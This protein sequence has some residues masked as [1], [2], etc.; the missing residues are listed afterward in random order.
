MAPRPTSDELWGHHT[1][2][3][4][5]EFTVLMP[6]G[7][8]LTCNF[9]RDAR[10]DKIKSDIW[11]RAKNEVM[12][13]LMNGP[14][15]YVFVGVTSD[16][17]K[18]DFFDETRRLCELKLFQPI[19]KLVQPEGD[20]EEQIT[21]S[22]IS[23]ALGIAINDFDSIKDVE[24]VD[25]RHKLLKIA[26]QSVIERK[27]MTSEQKLKYFFPVELDTYSR[28]G[29]DYSKANGL[30]D[31]W[32]AHI[33][34]SDIPSN[35]V[36]DSFD[37]HLRL[38][39]TPKEIAEDLRQK[40]WMT[41]TEAFVLKVV[42]FEEYLLGNHKLYDYKYISRVISQKKK[43]ELI[44]RRESDLLSILPN[45]QFLSNNFFRRSQEHFAN[46]EKMQNDL[47]Q[48][49]HR[50]KIR[51]LWQTDY[52]FEVQVN[53]TTYANVKDLDQIFVRVGIYH[54]TEALCKPEDTAC[55]EPQNPK[56]NKKLQFELQYDDIPRSARLCLCMC[57]KSSKK[58]EESSPIAY[59]NIPLFDH[60]G[61]LRSGKV[62]LSL[63]RV[64]KEHTGL[65]YPLG[66]TGLNP[67]RD[68]LGLEIEFE[69]VHVVFPP[70]DFIEHYTQH[71]RVQFEK[72]KDASK[73][74]EKANNSRRPS[75][76]T[77]EEKQ[78][79]E[80]IIQRDPLADM[81]ET[82]KDL[83][84]RLRQYL[85]DCLPNSLPKLLESVKWKSREE[86][87]E[88]YILLKQWKPI[89]VETALEL[90]ECKFTDP[91][92]RAFAIK[93]LDRSL[94]DHLLKQYL[95]QLVQVLLH[96]PYLRSDV[97][98]FLLK[99]SLKN[100]QV[101]N[102]LFWLLKAEMQDS[103]KKRIC[104]L[105]LESYCRGIG[106]TLLEMTKK[107]VEAVDKLVHVTDV[108]K[109]KR[110]SS[111]KECEKL[112]RDTFLMKD[113][114][115]CLDFVLNPLRPS[116]SLGQLRIEDC[117]IKNSAKRPLWL[118]WDNG[119]ASA[120]RSRYKSNM[121]EIIFKNGDDL[122]QD[123]LTLQV[124]T[125]MDSIWRSEGLDL[126]MLPYTCL[127]TGR[128]VGLIEVVKDARTVMNLQ[129]SQGFRAAYQLGPKELYKWFVNSKEG[130]QSDRL[131]TFTRSCAGYCVATFVLGIG[132]RNP[133]NIMINDDGQI[134]HIDFGHFLG[135]FKKK[136][137]ISRER[138]PFVLTSDFLFVIS[139]GKDISES[140]PFFKEFIDLCEKAY[141]ILRQHASLLI[142]LFTLMLST[143]IPE[144]QTPDDVEYLRT[145]L[146]VDKNEVEALSYFRNQLNEAKVGSTYTKIDWMFH[147][148]RR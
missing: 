22:Q 60:R 80:E 70:E 145:T 100:R 105:I 104:S 114:K 36:L 84:W 73:N 97:A 23:Q 59:G 99:R 79:V 50:N 121:H 57:S 61:R 64:P 26:N 52:N 109:D 93:N 28:R 77:D 92:V 34:L 140:N 53:M 72:N 87:C 19:L 17:K 49:I 13:R 42:G 65:L 128:Q 91:K 147:N 7:L 9:S 136:F 86:V 16:G 12:F 74:T 82:D 118:V 48:D 29:T 4:P 10:L 81:D 85:K 83:I 94:P 31:E 62:S 14:S 115:D 30:S 8:V 103:L 102:F 40:P 123:M 106:S 71:L 144:L 38:D 69:N 112:M 119:D 101:G 25:C 46:E 130:N 35:S 15:S 110:D 129:R 146:Q 113:Y 96:E 39:W 141:L 88:V 51:Q 44:I 24:F 54:G 142:T 6:N 32:P 5:C 116:V 122:R 63:W 138:V 98:E 11:S 90:L 66:I 124:I 108:L 111:L 95:L 37:Y 133:D 148:V 120:L 20:P 43:A 18:E 143:G 127:A 89:K 75:S 134:F 21:Q 67:E 2:P 1:M 68:A 33:Y 45:E 76:G 125:I 126:K 132:D 135:H 41:Q 107:Q 131:D 78:K 3:S 58:P 47:L 56:W 139:R 117:K 137:G 55:C 27:N